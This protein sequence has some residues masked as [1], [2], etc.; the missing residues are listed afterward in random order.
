MDGLQDRPRTSPGD[1]GDGDDRGR[2]REDIRSRRSSARPRPSRPLDE[3][4][5]KVALF[6]IPANHGDRARACSSIPPRR[7]S[8]SGP[9]EEPRARGHHGL[10]RPGPWRGGL[11][12]PGD[13]VNLMVLPGPG[14]GRR[15]APRAA[16]FPTT[17]PARCTRRFRSSPWA[18]APMLA[19]GRDHLPPPAPAPAPRSASR[20]STTATRAS[21]PSM[22]PPGGAVD[23]LGAAGA[24]MYMTPRRRGLRAAATG[25]DRHRCER[26][27]ARTR[28]ELT[29][30]GLTG[31]R[32]R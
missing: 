12:V 32:T 9:P 20:A 29:P 30:Y 6:D 10:G 18:R 22:C 2:H 7:R 1:L 21:S 5:K 27:P 31:N 8:A 15:T 24:S 13:E 26:C 23:R 11:L 25:A 19:A 17:R 16:Q 3:I 14:S 4:Q 28:G